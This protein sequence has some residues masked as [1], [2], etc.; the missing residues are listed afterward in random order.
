M[1]IDPKFYDESLR[2]R[3]YNIGGKR[4]LKPLMYFGKRSAP[5]WKWTLGN[6]I[7]IWK[8][9][10]IWRIRRHIPPKILRRNPIYSNVSPQS[11]RVSTNSP[12]YRGKA[13]ECI[14]TSMWIS[15][16]HHLHSMNNIQVKS[17]PR[18]QDV[19][20]VY[21]PFP[22]CREPTYE[23]EAKCKTFQMKIG[24]VCIW[25][26]TNFHNKSFASLS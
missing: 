23:S 25:K 1:K 10:R 13:A 11:H 20:F 15:T 6:Y 22:S 14:F 7:I 8:K 26:K 9:V 4:F 3:V 2:L 18:S 21:R 19:T 12:Q 16:A 24:F 17:Q 5:V